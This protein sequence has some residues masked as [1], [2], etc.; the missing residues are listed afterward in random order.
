MY[1]QLWHTKNST[2]CPHRF[3]YMFCMDL[4]TNS[5]DCLSQTLHINVTQIWPEPAATSDLT[6]ADTPDTTPAALHDIT[7]ASY[8]GCP[9]LYLGTNVT[10]FVQSKW[11]IMYSEHLP[12]LSENTFPVMVNVRYPEGAVQAA[13][14]RRLP[15]LD[16][17]DAAITVNKHTLW[18]NLWSYRG[19]LKY[20]LSYKTGAHVQTAEHKHNNT[21][22]SKRYR[23]LKQ[24]I[25]RQS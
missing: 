13:Y 18:G 9:G 7:P 19:P 15:P 14:R 5:F 12:L 4:R 6:P 10:S 24:Q 21:S 17:H 23:H 20:G 2:F 25:L 1:Q 8:I 11:G 22:T 16:P 3:V